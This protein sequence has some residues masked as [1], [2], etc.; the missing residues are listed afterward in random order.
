[1][2]ETQVYSDLTELLEAFP[3][4]L[5]DFDAQNSVLDRD[6]TDPPLTP[7][8]GDRYIIK[9]GATGV[10]AGHENDITE[11]KDG[12]W[13]YITPNPWFSVG[14]EDEG[15]MCIWNGFNWIV[16]AATIDHN[17]LGNTHNLTSDIDHNNILNTHNLTT[18]IDHNTINNA[19][20]LT[21]DIDHNTLTNTHNLTT[22]INHNLITNAHNLTTDINHNT[23]LNYA[24]NQHIDWT[25]TNQNLL[26]T[27]TITAEQLNINNVRVDGN[28]VSCTASM[29]LNLAGGSGYSVNIAGLEDLRVGQTL[30]VSKGTSLLRLYNIGEIGSN[31]KTT[32][33]NAITSLPNL[34]Q[35]NNQNVSFGASFSVTDNDASINQNCTT[36]GS[37]T[38]SNITLSSLANGI[39]KANSGVLSGANSVNL[40][41]EV[42]G[43]LLIISGG[44][45]SSTA[46]VNGKCMHSDS[47]SI[48]EAQHVYV[49][50]DSVM[51]GTAAF[52][53]TANG[54]LAWAGVSGGTRRE[55]RLD[56]DGSFHAR[57]ADFGAGGTLQ[58]VYMTFSYV[59]DDIQCNMPLKLATGTSVNEIVTSIS[60]SSTDN[61]LPTAKSVWDALE[62]ENFWDRAGNILSPHNAG[63]N[64]VL[65]TGRLEA[66]TIAV[67]DINDS[68]ILIMAWDEDDTADRT[69]NLKVFGGNRTLTLRS[70]VVLN[71]DLATYSFVSFLDT[72]IDS[73]GSYHI[74]SRTGDGTWR[75]KRG[76]G[77]KFSFQLRESGTFNEKGYISTAGLAV[78]SNLQLNGLTA[79][80]IVETDGSK[81]LVS[82]VKGT[83]YNKNFGTSAGEI[84]Q[85]NTT[86][87][88]T[89]NQSI[90]GEKTFSTK[91]I[92][93]TIDAIDSNGV[94]IETIILKAGNLIVPGNFT[95]TGDFV[96]NQVQELTVNDN[97]IFLN[98]GETTSGV[99][100][101]WSGFETDRGILDPYFTGFNETQ[102]NCRT[103]I[104]YY[105]INYSNLVNGPFA[106]H[107]EIE[108]I[109]DTQTFKGYIYSDTGSVLKIKGWMGIPQDTKTITGLTSGATATVSSSS[110]VDN[111]QALATREDAP[112]DQ[113]IPFWNAANVKLETSSNL[114]WDGS[115]LIVDSL[116]FDGSAISTFFSD[117]NIAP[118][119]NKVG[120]NNPS[121]NGILHVGNSSMTSGITLTMESGANRAVYLE[122]RSNNNSQWVTG[123]DGTNNNLLFYI[124]GSTNLLRLFKTGNIGISKDPNYKLDVAG[125]IN[126]D[127]GSVYRINGVDINANGAFGLTSGE[128]SQL[129]N[130]DS[131]TISNTQWGYLGALDQSLKTTDDVSFE[132]IT[133]ST[134][135]VQVGNASLNGDALVTVE[136]DGSIGNYPGFVWRR[137]GSERWRADCQVANDLRFTG[138]GGLTLVLSATGNTYCQ[139]TL[140][141]GG[142]IGVSGTRISKGWFTNL[143]STNY[144]IV[145]GTSINANGVLSLTSGEVTQ[146]ANID[147]NTISNTQWGYLGGLD[148][149]LAQASSPTFAGA[150]LSGLSTANGIV[151]TDG[152]GVLSSS[153][154]L[155]DGTLA[156]TQTPLDNSTKLATTAYV[157]SAVSA[158]NLWNRAGS[159]LSPYNA[160]DRVSITHGVASYGVL[161]TTTSNSSSVRGFQY[162]STTQNNTGIAFYCNV[163]AGGSTNHRPFYASVVSGQENYSRTTD[164]FTLI[165]SRP[166]QDGVAR[167]DNFDMMYVQRNT[168]GVSSNAQGTLLKLENISSEVN[169]TITPLRI[170]QSPNSSGAP[171][172]VDQ[173][174][175]TSTN[176]RKLIREENTGITYWISNGTDPNGALSG[177]TGDI[178]LN[179]TGNK[180]YYCTGTTNWTSL[181]P[182]NLASVVTKSATTTAALSDNLKVVEYANGTNAYTF[183]LP[184]NSE[185][186]FPVGSLIEIRKT[187]TGDITIAKGTGATFRGVF[188]DANVKIEGEDGYSVFA[189]KT[190][191]NTW[192][193]SGAV[194]VA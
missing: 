24:A 18:D 96:R 101:I 136:N 46:L 72:Q 11:F 164:L 69:L 149:A 190:A 168:T 74:G 172:S 48:V 64:V 141:L 37:P 53:E 39:V 100:S 60:G 6:L 45:N 155:P 89:G 179:G 67:N 166:H 83:A 62:T 41:S 99:S 138:P 115:K 111:T 177:T 23:L 16:F 29:T 142:T 143:E 126:I 167:T 161:V 93:S 3:F 73:D 158:E 133:S 10:W 71:Q 86:V 51:A 43:L 75:T 112:T 127:T 9:V 157:D 156:T 182:S 49:D 188:G 102:D 76:N 22:S 5:G 184:Q 66:D 7:I 8:E 70:N 186:A 181:V 35:I 52:G 187:G 185:V 154:T 162:N 134:G 192:L 55:W 123:I 175:V 21:T 165:C 90:A 110:L 80:Q 2:K 97:S 65:G 189:E 178:C 109:G 131:I 88:L 44:T 92:T 57:I 78:F 56:L 120:I 4:S 135:S 58:N 132:D 38:F 26:T 107:E 150:T 171:I 104:L 169:D 1:M 95:V 151:Q 50:S 174:A 91:I 19:H 84:A 144:P 36:T 13:E 108:I 106:L 193:I 118:G 47:G 130:I 114:K 117:I 183:S 94:N 146:L 42:T 82:V 34:A 31:T 25:N 17:S 40:G 59:T 15:V 129:A 54:H 122:W 159:V 85:G 81:Q 170:I 125:D 113:G 68:H 173:N 27:G 28:T 87:N 139:G 145:G 105:S 12:D 191:T 152:S 137:G 194:K 124:Q 160:N 63:D 121:P 128:V 140:T 147:T 30:F 20:N 180:P 98:A 119:T 79:S 103:G 14:V 163:S 148:Q 33:Q 77:N 176:F 153:V 116:E 61:Q 32:I